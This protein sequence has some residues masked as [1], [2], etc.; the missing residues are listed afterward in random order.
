MRGARN[1]VPVLA[2]VLLFGAVGG[3]LLFL[4]LDHQCNG[5]IKSHW[6]H[7]CLLVLVA[8]LW[9]LPF[10]GRFFYGLEYEDSYIY[11]VAARYL[12]NGNTF[13]SPIESCYLIS[14]CAVGYWNA[15]KESETFSGHFIGYPAMI[16]AAL[17]VVGYKSLI[18]S[19]LSLLAS[20]IAV[21]LIFL[22]CKLI[23]L[24][25]VAALSAS[26]IFCITPVFA[27]QGVGTY[28]EPVSN[29]FVLMCVHLCIRL[30]CPTLTGPRF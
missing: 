9:R 8:L 10:D 6:K 27:V 20:L 1:N 24:G 14:T 13:C 12:T 16:A 25:D 7:L 5:I 17:R 22:V 4:A 29:A 2:Y 30:F 18:A 21:A 23:K 26:L 3:S 11:A 28:A 15:C 19:E